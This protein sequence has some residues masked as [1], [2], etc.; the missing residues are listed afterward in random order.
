MTIVTVSACQNLEEDMTTKQKRRK[1]IVK[2]LVPVRHLTSTEFKT[3]TFIA[4]LVLAGI[5]VTNGVNEPVVWAF[6]GTAIGISLG[7][8]AN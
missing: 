3:I 2:G 6:L 8:S 4:T 7:H 5:A 1:R